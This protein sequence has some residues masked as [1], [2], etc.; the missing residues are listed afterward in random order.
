MLLK[1]FQVFQIILISLF[2]QCY[3]T[4]IIDFPSSNPTHR[5]ELVGNYIATCAHTTWRE[6]IEADNE[7]IFTQTIEL[8]TYYSKYV[9][10]LWKINVFFDIEEQEKHY[11][12]TQIGVDMIIFDQMTI[13]L[14][15]IP[16]F[17]EK[18]DFKYRIHDQYSITKKQ[19]NCTFYNIQIKLPEVDIA[20]CSFYLNFTSIRLQFLKAE[21][22]ECVTEVYNYLKIGN[23]TY[24]EVDVNLE[25]KTNFRLQKAND[26]FNCGTCAIHP[27]NYINYYLG[28]HSS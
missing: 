8:P 1:D 9:N 2:R 10:R 24:H 25:T 20:L 27:S 6:P 16:K 4:Q 18:V 23:F 12:F 5:L 14:P 22:S 3:E 17:A 26:L 15:G 21:K 19:T 11:A 28:L 7:S 13:G